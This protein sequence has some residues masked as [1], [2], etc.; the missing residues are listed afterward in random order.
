MK[1]R[2]NDVPPAE[3]RERERGDCPFRDVLLSR[4]I[5]FCVDKNRRTGEREK[6]R[7]RE[8]VGIIQTSS[9]GVDPFVIGH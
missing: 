3:S 9:S 8:S 1:Q 2:G 6:E 5:L 4:I 7:E